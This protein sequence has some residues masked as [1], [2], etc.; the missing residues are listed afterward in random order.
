MVRS[1]GPN[2]TNMISGYHIKSIAVAPKMYAGLCQLIRNNLSS[3]KFIEAFKLNFSVFMSK[4]CWIHTW[5][6]ATGIDVFTKIQRQ[7]NTL[8]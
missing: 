8:H 5:K 1:M 2:Y 6:I 4:I 7:N 3:F